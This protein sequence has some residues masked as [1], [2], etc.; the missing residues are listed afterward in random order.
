MRMRSYRHPSA[1]DRESGPGPRPFV[2]D[3]G[4]GVGADP[5]HSE[6][7]VGPQRD[8][9]QTLSGLHGTHGGNRSGLS[10]AATT[11]T[12]GP[13]AVAAGQDIPGPGLLASADC[14]TPPTRVS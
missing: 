8:E 12:L 10:A 9:G 1:E 6:P 5:P 13:L 2:A 7:R 4:N 3:N 14:R 11:Q